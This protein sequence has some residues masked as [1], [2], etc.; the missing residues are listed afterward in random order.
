MTVTG[1]DLGDF[2]II[3]ETATPLPDAPAC[4][5]D[6]D[7]NGVVN[8][9]DLL[10]LIGNWGACDPGVACPADLAPAPTGD[11]VV[12]VIDLLALIGG[13]GQCPE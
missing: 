4:P 2:V 12:N 11:G 13:W 3:D 7:G 10:A 1:V 8:V 9:L 6:L 5:P